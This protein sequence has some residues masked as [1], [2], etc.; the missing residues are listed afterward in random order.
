MKDEKAWLLTEKAFQMI[1]T[2]SR[3]TSIQ[4]L[5]GM[6]E[7]FVS[8]PVGSKRQDPPPL[9][10]VMFSLFPYSPSRFLSHLSISPGQGIKW[11]NAL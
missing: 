2:A 3:G 8:P 10:N 5:Y 1:G 4:T 6:Y 7:T 9:I 11:Q